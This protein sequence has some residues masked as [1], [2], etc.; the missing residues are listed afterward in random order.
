MYF[1]AELALLVWLRQEQQ[2][3]RGVARVARGWQGWS[4]VGGRKG[5]GQGQGQQHVAPPF[6][7]GWLQSAD[8]RR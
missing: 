2:M 6:V 7:E 8:P 4:S 1:L 3:G 5:Q